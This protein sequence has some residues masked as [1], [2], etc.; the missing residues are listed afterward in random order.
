M[1]SSEQ[2]STSPLPA[3]RVASLVVMTFSAEYLA[4]TSRIA[5]SIDDREVEALALSLAE[6]RDRGGRLFIL[7]AGGGAGHASHA[8]ND[9]RKLCAF[10][11][12]CPAD[13]TSEL[14]ARINDESWDTAYPAW[15]QG[16]RLDAD[17]ALLV[18]SVG[19]GSLDPAVSTSIVNAVQ[20]AH[21]RGA[22]IFGVV[23]PKGGET[24]RLST[25]CI[26]VDVPDQSR[27]TS[28]VEEFQAVIWHLLVVHP[29]LKA[30]DGRWESL[31]RGR[32]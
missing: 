30:Q 9:F 7:G 13:N 6:V 11:A 26:L 24:A 22:G 28:H 8:V 14:T 15:L 12:Y 16:S 19:G 1:R 27:M 32:E 31:D 2:E 18:F 29:L 21:E 25:N 10:E 23:G 20:L 5:T 3:T 4:E 17:D